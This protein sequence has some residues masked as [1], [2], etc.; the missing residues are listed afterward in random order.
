MAPPDVVLT[1][2][3]SPAGAQTRGTELTYTINYQN[4][5]GVARNVVIVDSIPEWM[6]YVSGSVS[7]ANM[8]ITIATMVG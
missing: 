2:T 8:D 7:G 3:V 1:K 4:Q 5:G 6:T